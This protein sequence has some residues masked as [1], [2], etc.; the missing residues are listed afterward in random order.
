VI[1][2]AGARPAPQAA[3][4]VLHGVAVLAILALVVIIATGG[5]LDLDRTDT[6]PALPSS[7]PQPA[8]A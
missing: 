3:L 6:I 8:V 2:G 1:D 7:V 5:R 4:H